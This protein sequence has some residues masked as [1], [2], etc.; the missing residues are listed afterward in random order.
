MTQRYRILLYHGVHPVNLDP[1]PRNSSGKHIPVDRFEAEMDF[2]ARFLSPISMR[3]IAAA[4]RGEAVLPSDA[5]AV[6]FDDGF[7]NNHGEAWPILERYHIPATFY[8]AT[9]YVG[10]RRMM[11]TDR[12]ET[13][14]FDSAR[15]R[16]DIV[17]GETA[18]RYPLDDVDGRVAAFEEIKA[19]CKSVANEVKDAVV[20]AVWE[21][22]APD[23]PDDHPL[24]AFMSWDEVREMARSSLIDFGAHTVDHVALSRVPSNVMQWQIDKSVADLNAALDIS[25]E[26]FSYPEGQEDDY[27]DEV[28]AHLRERNFD[29]APSAVDGIND[30]ATTNPFH[31]RRTMVGFEGRPFPFC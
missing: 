9:G 20:E 19:R 24:Y 10:T 6:T 22:M 31:L 3:E 21:Q 16:L 8:L 5:V 11:W 25:T 4:H 7:L 30:V 28:I 14:I 12:L 27:D 29:H 1:W 15:D 2:V 13:A 17:V 23:V 26:L 18:L